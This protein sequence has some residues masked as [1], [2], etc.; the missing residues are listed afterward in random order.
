MEKITVAT[1][2]AKYLAKFGVKNIFMLSGTGSIFLDDAFAHQKGIKHI[3]AR[4]EAAAVI[5]AQ[6][7]AKLTNSIGVVIATTGP[8]GTNAISGIVESWVDSVPVLVISGQVATSQNLKTRSFGVQGFDII[9]NVKKLT[10]YAV[11]VKSPNKIKYHIEK[12]IH[13]A[14][15]GRKGPVWLDIPFDVQSAKI[16]EKKLLSFQ[17]KKKNKKTFNKFKINKIFELI[18]NS[19][20]PIIVFGQGIRQSEIIN[21]FKKMIEYL[22]IPCI[23]ARMGL[24]ILPFNYKFFFGL[25]GMRGHRFSEKILKSTDLIICIGTSFSHAFAGEKFDQFN[26]KAKIAMVNIDQKEM[27]KPNLK[28]KI[29]IKSELKNFFNDL[30]FIYK[31]NSS[32]NFSKW[33]EECRFLKKKLTTVNNSMK[34][35]PINSYY[36]TK[37]LGEVSDKNSVFVNDA[38]SSNYV[39]SQALEIKKNQ[40]EIT[41]GAFYSMGLAVPMAIGASASYPKKTIIAITGDGSIELNIQELRTMSINRLNIKLFVINN[42]GYASIRKSQDDMTG[43]RYTD[44]E[45]VLDFNKTA[46]AFN[47]KYYKINKS[48]NI[49]KDLKKILKSKGPSLTEVF[50]DP[51]QKIIETFN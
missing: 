16:N 6:A 27:N 46:G 41:S 42:G 5:M 1:Y 9:S 39:C 13:Y 48:K 35:N 43:G 34:Q 18:Q 45:E 31:K 30:N 51:N 3:C 24:D 21:K 25:A 38:G 49:K 12:A 17:S 11:Q 20:K 7:S 32:K 2:L 22:K 29:K 8:G 19:K 4:H 10:K 28:I 14:C 33:L 23:T 44:D 47:I 36:F 37:C 26:K 15:S 40:R 50:C